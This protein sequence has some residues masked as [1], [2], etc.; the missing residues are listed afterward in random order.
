MA[1]VQRKLMQTDRALS[2]THPADDTLLMLGDV[3]DEAAA[4]ALVAELRAD[5]EVATDEL[6]GPDAVATAWAH[7]A[8]CSSCPDRRQRLMGNL[9]SALVATPLDEPSTNVETQIQRATAALVPSPG[10]APADLSRPPTTTRRT[11]FGR[12]SGAGIRAGSS[13]GSG[14]LAGRRA[15]IAV[16]AAAFALVGATVALQPGTSHKDAIAPATSRA[17]KSAETTAAAASET[18]AAETLAAS[19][20]SADTISPAKPAAEAAAPEAAV[21]DNAMAAA[22]T[23]AGAVEPEAPQITTSLA[24]GSAV[25]TPPPAPGGPALATLPPITTV[26]P[27]VARAKKAVA[28]GTGQAPAAPAPVAAAQADAMSSQSDLGSFSFATDALDRFG[29]TF[30]VVASAPPAAGAPATPELS[31]TPGAC[32][33]TAGTV[34]ATARIG[35]L[36]VLLV[37]VTETTG[38]SDLVLDARTCVEIARRPS[39]PPQ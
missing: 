18:A 35:E 17:A 39:P 14:V 34:R 9:T 1:V 31:Q 11:L 29:T 38:S 22:E 6:Y 24:P 13:G 3:F 28:T 25:F 19:E 16:G 2:G 36:P 15:W 37:R 23:T 21:N 20:F 4:T 5:P 7:L 30:P 26:A 12:R 10:A 27:S 32:P 8:T 33:Q